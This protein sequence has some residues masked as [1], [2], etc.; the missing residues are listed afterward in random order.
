MGATLQ[1]M[2]MAT[3]AEREVWRRRYVRRLVQLGFEEKF[4]EEDCFAALSTHDYDE[5][6]EEAAEHEAILLRSD[7]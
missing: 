7:G 4:A 3:H 6:P 1:A 5:S 2:G